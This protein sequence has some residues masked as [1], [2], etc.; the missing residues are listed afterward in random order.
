[1][2]ENGLDLQGF[3]APEALW[4]L[5]RLKGHEG[6]LPA[7]LED[8]RLDGS[9]EA[10]TEALAQAGLQAR[11]A[12]LAGA[13]LGCLAHPTLVGLKDGSWVLLRD[14]VR[15][16]FRV[17][18]PQGVLELPGQELRAAFSG[19]ALDLA[20]G[21]GQGSLWQKLGALAGQ[22][23]PELL[24]LALATAALQALALGG[25]LITRVV[26]DRALPDGAAALLELVAAG[27][28]FTALLQS[29]LGW[30]RGRL[31]LFLVC[32]MEVATERHFMD[33]LLRLPF[34]FLQ[35]QTV[36]DLLQAFS[37]LAAARELCLEKTLGALLDAIMAVLTLAAMAW[38]LP[39]ATVAVVLAALLIAA[40]TLAVGRVQARLRAAGVELQAREQGTLSEILAGIATLKA[41]GAAP[42]AHRRWTRLFEQ[43]LTLGLRQG[44]IRLWTD[45]ALAGLSQGLAVALLIWGGHRV[46]AGTLGLGSL[47][48]FLQ[49]SGT[50]MAAMLGGVDAVLAMWMLRPHLART[51]RILAVAP[52]PP[53][54][55]P[56]SPQPGPVLMEDVWFRY[57][58]AAPWV[59]EGF[60]LR[61]ET[62]AQHH[63]QGVSGSGKTTLLRLLA[64][65]FTPERGRIT[66]GGVRPQEAR[67]A[68]L[69]LPQTLQIMGGSVLENLRLLSGGA[70]REALLRAC[71]R[72]GLAE[73][74][75]TLPMGYETVLPHGGRSLSGG[76]RQLLAMTAALASG[77]SVLLLDE[78]MANLDARRA[79]V[80][81]QALAEGPWTVI[82]ASHGRDLRAAGGTS[83]QRLAY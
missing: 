34:P 37:G 61:V 67:H 44:R 16:R 51:E 71:E 32:R 83:L 38:L 60:N 20:P 75:A 70:P 78:A 19:Q 50:F 80:L 15:S 59:L 76:Q 49:L 7:F 58:P 17:E 81:A 72:T 56:P 13:D 39:A 48:A 79:S 46:L 74:L 54:R 8:Q 28:L 24:Q 68:L 40:A 45:T 53:P 65:L 62:G 73:L 10:M 23:R 1:M 21:L 4:R 2:A 55:S 12:V 64:G 66:L 35:S 18:T 52:E 69:Y 14:R 31:V 30:F 6:S 25:P 77:R 36:G 5:L 63:L 3:S 33:H 41:A 22:H 43:G 11:M 82:T 57:H 26:L 27:I 42:T 29:W 9:P 47:F